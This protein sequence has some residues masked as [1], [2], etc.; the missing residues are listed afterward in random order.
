MLS[1]L[2]Q[3]WELIILL[4]YETVIEMNFLLALSTILFLMTVA[5]DIVQARKVDSKR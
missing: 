3:G 1:A 5:I 4:F 2:Q